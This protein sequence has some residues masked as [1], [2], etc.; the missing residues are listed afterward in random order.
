MVSG[1]LCHASRATD[2]TNTTTS[3]SCSSCQLGV[4]SGDS[5]ATRERFGFFFFATRSILMR[6][7]RSHI[8]IF[9]SHDIALTKVVLSNSTVDLTAESSTDETASRI[10]PA[11]PA[12]HMA[13]PISNT[14]TIVQQQSAAA[15]KMRPVTQ[16]TCEEVCF[17][18]LPWR[19]HASARNLTVL[20]G[21]DVFRYSL[22]LIRLAWLVIATLLLRT[23]LRASICLI[24]ARFVTRPA[25]P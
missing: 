14:P 3:P 15:A 20:E 25:V 1:K 12:K 2:H 19:S 21:T 6:F 7:S 17:V 5:Q 24:L 13:Q 23:R 18:V 4:S 11:Q 9:T 8:D 16:W 10:E 22:G